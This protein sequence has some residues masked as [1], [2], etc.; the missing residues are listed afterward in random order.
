MSTQQWWRATPIAVAST[1]TAIF[2][3]HAPPVF[4]HPRN[5]MEGCWTC[6]A[7]WPAQ[8]QLLE[9]EKAR[10]ERNAANAAVREILSRMGFSNEPTSHHP[11][12]RRPHHD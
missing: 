3:E 2:R 6:A 5:W 10:L 7:R 11:R 4:L 12:P 9:Q 1:S 8:Q